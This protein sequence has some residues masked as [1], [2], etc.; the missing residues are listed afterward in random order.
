MTTLLSNA[1]YEIISPSDLD[2]LLGSLRIH[3]GDTSSPYTYSD[4][5][6][7]KAL[8]DGFKA[9]GKRWQK[10]Y[11]ISAADYTV[12]SGYDY[13]H[14]LVERTANYIFPEAA[15]PVILFEDERAIVLSAAIGIRSG[16]LQALSPTL[17]SWRD[18]E[19]SQSNI[20]SGK[21]LLSLLNID[22]SSLEE[23]FPSRAR[24]LAKSKKG[25]LPG[26]DYTHNLYEGTK[27]WN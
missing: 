20:E 6:L 3:L 13:G 10:R 19:I 12:V 26:F 22:K 11:S 4:G 9:L 14:Y 18:D 17:G 15:P 25:S 2:Y 24:K 21:T 8:V 27:D 23:L 16:Q 7:R 5:Y 1:A